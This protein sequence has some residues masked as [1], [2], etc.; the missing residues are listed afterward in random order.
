MGSPTQKHDARLS[1]R[2]CESMYACESVYARLIERFS[3]YVIS[4]AVP[5]L[6]VHVLAVY[7][8]ADISASVVQ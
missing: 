4:L 1:A 5:V 6:A 2:I 7:V 8:L 3:C